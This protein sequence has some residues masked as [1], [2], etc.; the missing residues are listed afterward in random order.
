VE[1]NFHVIPIDS[2]GRLDDKPS[3]DQLIPN[4]FSGLETDSITSRKLWK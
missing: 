3:C 4:E 1:N 2:H